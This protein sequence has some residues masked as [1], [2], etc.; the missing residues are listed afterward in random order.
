MKTLNTQAI[1]LSRTEFGEADRIITFLTPN[2]GKVKGLAKGV[3]KTKSKLAG[4]I[5]LFSVSDISYIVG[6]GEI[7]TIISTRLKEHFGQIV[8][9]I[10][11]TNAGYDFIKLINKA[12]EDHPEPA[13]F[14]LMVQGFR[15]LD[16]FT[17]DLDIVQLWFKAQLLRLAGHSPNLTTDENGGKLQ[18]TAR[19]I[20]N[21]ET[22]HFNK[23]GVHDISF[24]ARSIKFLRLVFSGNLPKTL[25]KVQGSTD[26][27]ANCLPLVSAMLQTYTRI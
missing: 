5:E 17:V 4:G 6:R 1:V 3:R 27:A 18:E 9:N 23:D 7:C 25:A 12:T 8:K 11:R 19:Y 15:A 10:E 22:M 14:E 20:F 16:D 26:I 24:D 21:F 13:Y 2:Q